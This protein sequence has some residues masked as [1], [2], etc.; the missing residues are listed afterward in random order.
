[1]TNSN[2]NPKPLIRPFELS[3]QMTRFTQPL[4]DDSHHLLSCRDLRWPT[5]LLIWWNLKNCLDAGYLRRRKRVRG[6]WELGNQQLESQ[7]PWGLGSQVSRSVYVDAL[8]PHIDK[9]N[10]EETIKI[11]KTLVRFLHITVHSLG[12]GACLFKQN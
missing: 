9:S 4:V 5:G 10:L 12:L 2:G 7:K 11:K 1:M 6:K 3:R 8:P